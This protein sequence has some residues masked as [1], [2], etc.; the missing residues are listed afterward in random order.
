[1]EVTREYYEQQLRMNREFEEKK[2]LEEKALNLEE[3]ETDK[4]K[5]ALFDN[6]QKKQ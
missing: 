5:T 1:M 4:A 3:I 6:I 2:K